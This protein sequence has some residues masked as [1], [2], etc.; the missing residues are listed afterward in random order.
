MGRS[1]F[2]RGTSVDTISAIL[3]EDPA[4]FPRNVTTELQQI[5]RHCL[6]KNPERRFQTAVDLCFALKRISNAAESPRIVTARPRRAVRV[7]IAL[8]LVIVAV[9][10]GLRV[11]GKKA[12]PKIAAN[13]IRSI[14]VL[15]LT[16]LSEDSKQEYFTD[17]MTEAL[18]ADLA[19]VKALKVIS[20]T[21]IMQYK[22]SKKSLPQIA[23]ELNVDAVLEGSV[24]RSGNQVR[25]TAQ[26]IDARSDV[27]LWAESYER[28]LQDV[29]ALQGDIARMV[30]R[31]I[32]VQLT[33]QEDAILRATRRVNPEAYE[34]YLKGRFYYQTRGETKKGSEYFERAIEIDPDF[35]L[36]HAVLSF[37]Y[38]D[39][40]NDPEDLVRAKIAARKA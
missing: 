31:E 14:A 26:L 1:P 17:G 37:T 39:L 38:A 16:D 30:A 24:M 40:A 9:V 13:Q 6:E 11:L 22:G 3:N 32:K 8:V 19:K 35:A 23:R 4:P 15:P 7:M 2:L 33:P 27:H 18:I 10:I 21:S 25:I 12:A 5:V 34:T 20:R 36:S 28:D 29:L